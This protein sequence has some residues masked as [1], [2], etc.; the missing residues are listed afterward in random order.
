MR[1]AASLKKM[2]SMI[3]K[4]RRLSPRT[5]Y[6]SGL[7]EKGRS[8]AKSE[9]QT[10]AGISRRRSKYGLRRRQKDC[11]PSRN[12]SINSK[13]VC[14]VKARLCKLSEET[15][16]ITIIKGKITLITLVAKPPRA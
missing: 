5:N 1:I 7:R 10:V 6:N 13:K 12:S 14:R 11:K 4:K 3:R 15:L 9:K 2:N 8:V 16:K